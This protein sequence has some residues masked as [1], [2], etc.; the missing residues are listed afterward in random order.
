M[1]NG[2]TGSNGPAESLRQGAVDIWAS[3]G[4]AGSEP[5]PD[6]RALERDHGPA[7]LR[8]RAAGTLDQR[9][10]LDRASRSSAWMPRPGA[11]SPTSRTLSDITGYT[12]SVI[13]DPDTYAAA[14]DYRRPEPDARRARDGDFTC[15]RLAGMPT[16]WGRSLPS[17]DG[18]PVGAALA[19]RC[20]P[21]FTT[22]AGVGRPVP[23]GRPGQYPERACGL[24]VRGACREW[25]SAHRR[26]SPPATPSPRTHRPRRSRSRAALQPG[27]VRDRSAGSCST[28]RPM[29]PRPRPP[30]AGATGIY[31]TAPDPSRV[32]AGLQLKPTVLTAI[33]SR[34]TSG[35]ATLA[36]RRRGRGRAGTLVRRGCPARQCRGCRARRPA[37]GRRD[38]RPGPR[39]VRRPDRHASPAAGSAL[40]SGL[41]AHRGPPDSPS[42]SAW[43]RGP[44]S[45]SATAP[46]RRADRAQRWSWTGARRRSEPARTGRSRPAGS[47][48]TASTT[49]RRSR[50]KATWLPESSRRGSERPLEHEEADR[51]RPR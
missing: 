24:G 13:V 47:C 48:S 3:S 14:G 25:G 19:G 51:S 39:L 10:V 43:T 27:V 12:V 11:S 9:R 2:Y 7:R 42:A 40:G 8:V 44:P 30:I 34:W 22:P 31:L 49:G 21:T 29:P 36:R 15:C 41:P 1:I 35:A 4:V 33:R 26:A 18:T 28:A 37:V 20:L 32:I 23:R 5:R 6:L 16:I 17:L 45:R 38:G 46:R 50:R